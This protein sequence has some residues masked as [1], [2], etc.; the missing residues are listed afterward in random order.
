VLCH[1]LSTTGFLQLSFR[2]LIGD[3]LFYERL[4][5]DSKTVVVGYYRRTNN[6]KTSRWSDQQRNQ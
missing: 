5:M 6:T 3:R 2:R 4:V 1:L